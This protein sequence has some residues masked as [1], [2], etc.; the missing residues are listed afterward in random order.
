[1]NVEIKSV[2]EIA[3]VIRNV[4]Q[5]FQVVNLSA[6]NKKGRQLTSLEQQL[7]RKRH[8]RTNGIR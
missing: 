4:I 6:D 3:L 7:F 1:M 2:S 8:K 5:L